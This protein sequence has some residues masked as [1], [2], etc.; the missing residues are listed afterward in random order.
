MRVATTDF[1]LDFGKQTVVCIA[2][3]P[4]LTKED[5]NYV[6]GRARVIA[7]NDA[8]R[9][10]PWADVL[11]ACDAKWWE[12]HWGRGAALFPGRKFGLQ[13][14]NPVTNYR[15]PAS[16]VLLH[17]AGTTGFDPHGGIVSGGNSG[18]QALQVAIHAGA[19]RVV[20]LGYDMQE[21]GGKAHFFG[22]HPEG[23]QGK[24]TGD[25]YAGWCATFRAQYASM[26]KMG[27][28]IVNCTPGSKLDFYPQAR[29]R[30]AL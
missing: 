8:F 27:V 5:V 19:S 16:V 23:L 29:I 15:V 13:A 24:R 20:L 11:Y 22:D 7:I 14:V 9:L 6:R 26:K 10:A 18:Y 25:K 4:S 3:G 1:P 21:R 17:H 12:Y 2:T 28:N 30:S